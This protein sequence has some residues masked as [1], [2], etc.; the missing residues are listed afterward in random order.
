MST[1]YSHWRLQV[2]KKDRVIKFSSLYVVNESTDKASKEY[3]SSVALESNTTKEGK[4][5]VNVH[6][7]WNFSLSVC[8]TVHISEV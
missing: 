6:Y 2:L 8:A 4:T 7:T 5:D 3:I 1:Y